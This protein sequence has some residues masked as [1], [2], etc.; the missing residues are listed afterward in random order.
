MPGLFFFPG[1]WIHSDPLSVASG[2]CPSTALNSRPAPRRDP[3]EQERQELLKDYYSKARQNKILEITAKVQ[4]WDNPPEVN[5]VEVK[6]LVAQYFGDCSK[7]EGISA[8]AKDQC[9]RGAEPRPASGPR[10]R[11]RAAVGTIQDPLQREIAA[12]IPSR[13]CTEN[14]RRNH[15][16]EIR[17]PCTWKSDLSSKS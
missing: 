9:A 10:S 2:W 12:V 13:L 17:N 6:H 1:L 4:A 16:L 14:S 8:M 5:A 3:I 11:S 15:R 7:E